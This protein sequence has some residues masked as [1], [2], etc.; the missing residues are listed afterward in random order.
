MD[1][2]RLQAALSREGRQVKP[3]VT[4]DTLFAS[5]PVFDEIVHVCVPCAAVWLAAPVL[6]R[7]NAVAETG[8]HNAAPQNDEERASFAALAELEPALPPAA[9]AVAPSDDDGGPASMTASAATPDMRVRAGHIEPSDTNDEHEILILL[10]DTPEAINER[11]V[12]PAP[13]AAVHQ[14]HGHDARKRR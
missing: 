12:A 8:T 13:V 5:F 10:D 7:L 6:A 2:L 1:A 4:C 14:D 11:P 3:C 9:Q